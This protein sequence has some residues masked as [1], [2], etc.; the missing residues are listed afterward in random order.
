MK[1]VL[2]Y[3]LMTNLKSPLLMEVMKYWLMLIGIPMISGDFLY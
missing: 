2:I 1:G 3:N